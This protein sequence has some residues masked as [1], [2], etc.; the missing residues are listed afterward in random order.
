MRRLSIMFSLLICASCL[1]GCSTLPATVDIPV[2]VP[3]TPPPTIH[4]PRLTIG[5]LKADSPPADVIRA[6]EESLEQLG[7]YAEYLEEL[8]DGYRGDR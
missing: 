3:C 1:S 6:Y 8:L 4:R 7:G 5:T 2:A